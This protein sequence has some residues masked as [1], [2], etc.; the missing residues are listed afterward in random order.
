MVSFEFWVLCSLALGLVVNSRP[1]VD[2]DELQGFLLP[3]GYQRQGEVRTAI[4]ANGMGRVK[5]RGSDWN[6]K[7]ADGESIPVGARVHIIKQEN[8]TL[9]VSLLSLPVIG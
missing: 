6:A 1:P 3:D 2:S 9:T 5:F 4:P 8:T 7:T